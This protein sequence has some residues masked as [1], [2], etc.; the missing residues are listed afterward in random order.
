MRSG[1]A[2]I[3]ETT[4]ASPVT[5]RGK[6]DKEWLSRKEAA[7]F[8]ESIGCPVSPRSLANMA[9]NNNAGKGPSFQRTRWKIVRYRKRDL[10]EWAYRETERIK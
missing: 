4:S 10:E 7:A 3:P 1:N 9:S 6:F 5:V 2:F 8:L